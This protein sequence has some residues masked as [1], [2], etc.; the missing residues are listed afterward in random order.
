[1]SF[2]MAA[3]AASAEIRSAANGTMTTPTRPTAARD[4]HD[5]SVGTRRD[6]RAPTASARTG[7]IGARSVAPPTASVREQDRGRGDRS[8][9]PSPRQR[10][11]RCLRARSRR[12]RT[13]TGRARSPCRATRRAQPAA[14]RRRCR[15]RERRRERRRRHERG[16]ERG[17]PHAGRLRSAARR[18]CD[19]RSAR[20]ARRGS[21]RRAAPRSSGRS[22]GRGRRRHGRPSAPGRSGRSARRRARSRPRRCPGPWSLTAIRSRPGLAVT[23]T[24]TLPPSG[25]CRT[26]LPTRFES[27]WPHRCSS[28]PTSRSGGAVE[29]RSSTSRSSAG[30]RQS[31]ARRSRSERAGT[32]GQLE[33]D[34]SGLEL[35]EVEQLLDERAE[36]LDLVE[37]LAHALRGDLLD[38]V[39]EVLEAGAEGADRRAELVRGVRDEVAAHAV[40]LVQL[41]RH[42]VE[43]PSELADLVPGG[44]RDPARVVASCHR[45]G[46]GHHLPQRR[47]HP[48]R[49]HLDD[50]E[51][52]CR[53][54]EAADQRARGRAARRAG[55]RRP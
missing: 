51:R 13:A 17:E 46:G 27:T 6:L 12:R 21:C 4:R 31:L 40:G 45:A 19:S 29:V 41:R 33:R 20:P 25:E 39:D 43:R 30:S 32:I 35:G 18:P 8:R 42:R 3:K 1:M 54:G 23:S 26:A 55:R 47:G 24:R 10:W 5:R 9:R 16:R 37:H 49:E 22:R 36:P 50:R 38:A 53:R 28:T 2:A 7:A 11:R 44:R 52:E 14:R 15:C 34:R 48:V